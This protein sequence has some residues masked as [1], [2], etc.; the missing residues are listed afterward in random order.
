MYSN[1]KIIVVILNKKNTGYSEMCSKNI[2][3]NEIN[4]S[5]KY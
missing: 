5:V 1:T 4:C 3:N 2:Q